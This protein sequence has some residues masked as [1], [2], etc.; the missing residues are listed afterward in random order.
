MAV[1]NTPE[2]TI[3][4]V[5]DEV[6]I[7]MAEKKTLSQ[8]GYQVVLAHSGEAA[9]KILETGSI[10][11]DLILM[12]INLGHGMDG[13]EAARRILKNVDIPIIFLS[14]HTEPDVVEK[15]ED[16]TSYGY[17]VKNS[18][19]AVLLASIKMAFRLYEAKQV[20]LQKE[21]TILAQE[22]QYKRLI[23][24]LGER[25]CVFTHDLEGSFLYASDG[26]SMFGV[27]ADEII[28]QNWRSIR[29]TEDS[30]ARGNKADEDII[31]TGE[32]QTVLLECIHSDNSR[33]FIEVNYG[34]VYEGDEITYMEGICT[35]ITYHKSIE[36]GLK[37]QKSLLD[38]SQELA[39][40]GHWA[41]DVVNSTLEW[42]D[43]VFRIFGVDRA[44]FAVS[45]EN[46][47]G[48]I[49]REDLDDFKKKRDDMLS[50]GDESEIVHRIVLPDSTIK[51]VVER[52]SVIRDDQGSTIFVMGTIQDVSDRIA[53]ENELRNQISEKELLLREV[54]HR[55]KNNI[56][57]IENLI[58]LKANTTGCEDIT[59]V[60][61]D[62]I[63]RIGSMRLL[64]D[65]L[66]QGNEHQQ[67]SADIYIER[68]CTA[69]FDLYSCTD[70]IQLK[71]EVPNKC[72]EQ[73]LMFSTGVILNELV[74]NSIKYGFAAEQKGDVEVHLNVCDANI[75]LMYRDN[76]TG[77][78]NTQ[79]ES[80]TG[81]GLKLIQMLVSQ[82]GGFFS[83]ES[84]D[85]VAVNIEMPLVPAT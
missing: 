81:F 78:D 8:Y 4:L 22:E 82:R 44:D 19:K 63:S 5:E 26:F 55:I 7:A 80:Y 33:R 40:I 18:D 56:V 35:D 43:E 46:F 49:H 39:H 14:S 71:V 53:I 9:V 72:L 64:Y 2:K 23:D 25:H 70:R 84:A 27:R 17:V 83:I 47:E 1:I 6:I 61:K 52:S 34:P 3:I 36:A 62:V 50:R 85:G 79:L 32:R 66:T 12:D 73:Q 28:G 75:I 48:A 59:Y 67:I 24:G 58:H 11:I 15:T 16:I 69:I 51:T 31:N 13:P 76:G 41:W 38:K 30:I 60:F 37:R 29:F 65:M 77:F 10:K 45:V 42:S 57:S 68:L 20:E 74:T 54:Y 21:R